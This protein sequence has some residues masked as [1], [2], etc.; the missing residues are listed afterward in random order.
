SQNGCH[1]CTPEYE[2]ASYRTP[3]AASALVSARD[4]TSKARSE[5]PGA[6]GLASTHP[7]RRLSASLSRFATVHRCGPRALLRR[8][9][10]SV[11]V[12]P[13][14]LFH[15]AGGAEQPAAAA[16]LE[17]LLQEFGRNASQMDVCRLE[18]HRTEQA[19]FVALLGKRR[20]LDPRAIRRKP[21]RN[22]P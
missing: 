17:V 9:A 2:G 22:P 21:P 20:K 4:N 15:F 12:R 3:W 11:A 13:D 6:P 1:D 10:V 14:G 7:A 5:A 18:A 16:L 8:R 19:H